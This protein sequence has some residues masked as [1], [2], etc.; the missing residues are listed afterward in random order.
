MRRRHRRP[1]PKQRASN[2]QVNVRYG[3][4]IQ[5]IRNRVGRR[6]GFSHDN[7]RDYYKVLGY[8]EEPTV[9]DYADR[10]RRQDIAARINDLPAQDSWK[11][12]PVLIDGRSRSDDDNV[13]GQTEFIRAWLTLVESGSETSVDVYQYFERLDRLTGIGHYG[14]LLFGMRGE[15]GPLSD[16]MPD[17]GTRLGVNGLAY[18]MP[19]SEEFATILDYDTDP[20]SPRFGQPRTYQINFGEGVG[21]QRVHWT[22]ALHVIE[23][24]LNSRVFGRPRLERVVNRLDDLL[25]I[26]GGSAEATW[27]LMRKGLAI[28]TQPGFKFPENTDRKAEL[29]AQLEE[30]EHGLTRILKLNGLDV[31]EMGS[32]VVDP[33]GIFEIIISLLSAA[34]GI[35]QKILIGST[36]AGLGGDAAGSQDLL[37]WSNTVR[38]R[39]TNFCEPQILRPFVYWCIRH[40]VLPPPRSGRF[41]VQWEPIYELDDIER[42]NRA[43]AA[44]QAIRNYVQATGA[45]DLVE[46][47]E[48]RQEY[49]GLPPRSTLALNDE[50]TPED[51]AAFEALNNPEPSLNGSGA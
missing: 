9:E 26:V 6:F 29:D 16:P 5:A 3:D 46:P 1:T 2:Y 35:P 13:A 39:Q 12:R 21:S 18:L 31:D 33:K 19:Y 40:G 22:R 7:E 8:P 50:E 42:A 20:T 27:K 4:P 10:Y 36:W 15:V 38:A 14:V 17:G 47:N 48:F 28:K 49:L 30:Y 45:V 51:R 44:S 25:K 41:E 11:L 24:G 37:T 32:E 34:S 23:D 43:N